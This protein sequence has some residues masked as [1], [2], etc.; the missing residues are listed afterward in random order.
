MTLDEAGDGRSET[1]VE[2]ADRNWSEIL[3]ELRVAQT[4]T[5][6]LGGFLLAV[7]FQP[8][9]TELDAYQ[10]G[11]YLVLVALAGAAAVLA[12]A[13]VTLH[14]A[15][16]GRHRKAHV[17]RIGSRLLAADLVVVAVLAVGVTSLVF[18]F[19]LGRAA[20]IAAI[21]A[22]AVVVLVLW[23]LVPRLGARR[24]PDAPAR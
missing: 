23:A 1:P 22:G 5:Q 9:F 18:D 24:D 10:L 8:R 14:R 11:L 2:R 19:A 15:F 4:G 3:Q 12:I 16:F 13:P 7:A 20:G 17:V 6:I 21:A